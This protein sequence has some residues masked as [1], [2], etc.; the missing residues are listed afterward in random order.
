MT[1]STLVSSSSERGVKSLSS[2]SAIS[3]SSCAQGINI[4]HPEVLE[5]LVHLI[6]SCGAAMQLLKLRDVC[7]RTSA[8]RGPLD[9][10]WSAIGLYKVRRL[11][12]CMMTGERER[13]TIAYQFECVF[14]LFAL[15]L[16]GDHETT[17]RCCIFAIMV[18]ERTHRCLKSQSSGNLESSAFTDTASWQTS[19]VCL[20]RSVSCSSVRTLHRSSG[21]TRA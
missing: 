21:C 5:D 15:S 3:A 19:D 14:L 6:T 8:N 1:F 4:N 7:G 18:G 20:C 16:V 10:R 2:A 9:G 13:E 17:V 11:T 12:S